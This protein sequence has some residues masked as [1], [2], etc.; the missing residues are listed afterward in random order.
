MFQS[1]SVPTIW[2]QLGVR[3]SAVIITRTAFGKTNAAGITDAG[4]ASLGGPASTRSID[5]SWFSARRPAK[6]QPAVPPL[7]T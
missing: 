2:A 5:R 4:T 6:T 1:A 3:I 7:E